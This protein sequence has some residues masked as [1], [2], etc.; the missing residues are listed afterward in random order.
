MDTNILCYLI[1][2]KIDP[3]KWQ[4]WGDDIHWINETDNTPENKTILND[5]MSNYSSYAEPIIKAKE[6][7]DL[8][9]KSALSNWDLTNALQNLIKVL[10]S[11]GGLDL[12][13][14]DQDIVD[15]LNEA[16]SSSIIIVEKI[17]G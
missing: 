3:T 13:D 2:Q 16:T 17:N 10:E 7:S 14:L 11:K 5:I 1:A 4:L 12:K 6:K 9:K 15:K 8:E